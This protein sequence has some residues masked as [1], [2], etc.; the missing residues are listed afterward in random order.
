MA[1]DTDPAG[2]ARE[3]PRGVTHARALSAKR[4]R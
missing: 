1:Y 3:L 2:R 4:G